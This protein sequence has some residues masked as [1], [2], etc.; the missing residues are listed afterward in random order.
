MTESIT[1][2]QG[3]GDST[4]DVDW[5]SISFKADEQ[6][7]YMVGIKLEIS[8]RM[9]GGRRRQSPSFSIVAN[10]SKNCTDNTD[11]ERVH[12]PIAGIGWR[13]AWKKSLLIMSQNYGRRHVI[14]HLNRPPKLSDFTIHQK[15]A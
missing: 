4:K 11:K 9:I 2:E 15:N 8:K 12:V 1:V 3:I 5:H 14:R 7:T 10:R 13:K 6:Q